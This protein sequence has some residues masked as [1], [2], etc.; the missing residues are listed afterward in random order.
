MNPPTTL[1]LR[2]RDD[3]RRAAGAAGF[4]LLEV[5]VAMVVIAIAVFPSLEIIREAEK[6][7]FD[8]KYAELC[9]SKLR[10]LL[11]EITRTQKPGTT[12]G[13]DLSTMTTE[14]GGG[15]DRTAYANIKYEWTCSSVDLSLDIT[16]AAD[17]TDEEK[18]QQKTKRE[19]LDEA[20]KSDE[21]DA[22]I[23][24]RFRARYVRMVCNYKLE[25][26]EERQII[27]ETYIPPFPSADKDKANGQDDLVPP[28]GGSGGSGKSGGSGTSKKNSS[29]SGSGTGKTGGSSKGGGSS[30]SGKGN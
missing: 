2:R 7:S 19:K 1:Q 15:D 5:L 13:G 30:K 6:N 12:G 22:A 14:E 28:N 17:Q 11:S 3:A 18:D 20:K 26:G 16:P 25:N 10:S 29:T 21:A 24:D 23:D 9:T 4:T 8:A 27:V